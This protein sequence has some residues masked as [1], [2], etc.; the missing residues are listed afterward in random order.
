MF[1]VKRGLPA[2]TVGCFISIFS[3]QNVCYSQFTKGLN[4][5]KRN[6]DLR[7]IKSWPTVGFSSE[8]TKNGEYFMYEITNQPVG[9]ST[10][11]V[12]STKGTWETSISGV[13]VGF[14]KTYFSSD[15]KQLIY[16]MSDSLFFLKLGSSA[17]YDK[18]VTNVNN[19]FISGS[20]INN[21]LVY[22]SKKTKGQTTIYNLNNGKELIV[23]DSK[24]FWFKKNGQSFLI[25]TELE[26]GYGSVNALKYFDF[27]KDE[28][29]TI[30]SDTLN[31]GDVFLSDDGCEVAFSVYKRN[32]NENGRTSNEVAKK[33]IWYFKKGMASAVIKINSDIFNKNENIIGGLY[34]NANGNWLVFNYKKEIP[35]L[36]PEENAVKVKVW[37]YRD[38]TIVP[39]QIKENEKNGRQKTFKAAINLVTN[40]LMLLENDS[41]KLL[42]GP[43]G[44]YAIIG[45]ENFSDMEWWKIGQPSKIILLSL[46]DGKRTILKDDNL[47]LDNFSFSPDSKWLIYYD[48][49]DLN[50][51]SYNLS[52]GKILNITKSIPTSFKNEYGM[53]GTGNSVFGVVAWISED[54]SFILNDNYDIWQ[55]DPSGLRNAINIT[56]GYGKKNKI[57]L[58]LVYSNEVLFGIR[59]NIINLSDTLLISGFSVQNKYNGFFRKILNE[60][61]N[62]EKLFMGPYTF[63][64]AQSQKENFFSLSDG[65]LPLKAN[66]ANVWIVR[67]ETAGNSKN[68]FVTEDFKEYRPLTNLYP[69]K[70]FNWLTAHLIT[71]KQLDGTMSQGILYK[72]ENYDSTKKYPLLITYYEKMSQRLYEF[73]NPEYCT[74]DMN[75]PWFVTHGYL[76]F[77]PDIHYKIAA[78]SGETVGESAY[79]SIV[80]AAQHLIKLPYVDKT[81]LGIMGHSFGGLETN[82]LITH[83]KLFA[84]ACEFAGTS[85]MVSSYLTLVPFDGTVEYYPKQSIVESG[86]GRIGATLWEKPDLYLKQSAVLH[87]DKVAAPLLIVHNEKDGNVNWRQGLEM[88]MALRRLGKKAWMLQYDDYHVL[89]DE[90]NAID[91]TIRLTQYFDHYLKDAPAPTWLSNGIPVDQIGMKTAYQFD[92]AGNCGKGCKVCK[93]WNEK[94]KKDSLVTMKEIQKRTKSAYLSTLIPITGEGFGDKGLSKNNTKTLTEP[95]AEAAYYIEKKKNKRK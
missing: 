81:K 82:Y 34:L 1:N 12:A 67:R 40:K 44:D 42:V 5:R 49:K 57:K 17:P 85:D 76:V 56:N 53:E 88:Y 30:W 35:V 74:G 3:L 95:I 73:P 64:R 18:V 59:K 10:L 94:W 45:G 8:I 58:R 19:F 68:Y 11:V 51:F 15:S 63:Y 91:F 61:G 86:G 55:V 4:L 32:I 48:N 79:N 23:P 90:K 29:S 84:A 52:T 69:E 83:S 65:M 71:W 89:Q 77:T 24:A 54:N 93:M 66:S 36:A 9:S 31:C 27:E 87:V 43:I 20:G 6:L 13:G 62:P 41:D 37:S 72:P 60:K 38:K 25:K 21:W 92:P 78:K 50:F 22:L 80:S 75:I 16:Q 2:F 70:E 14:G 28:L 33:S 46:K 47:T 26:S 39:E 7:D